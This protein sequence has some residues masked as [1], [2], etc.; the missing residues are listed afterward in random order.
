M[1]ANQA[2]F[3]KLRQG[4]TNLFSEEDKKELPPTECIGD[5]LHFSSSTYL[6]ITV[7]EESKEQLI[8][9][10]KHSNFEVRNHRFELQYEL[11][12][13]LGE[14]AHAVVKLCWPRGA[15]SDDLFAVKITRSGDQEIMENMR[16]TFLNSISLNHPYVV[17][18]YKLYIDQNEETAY[19]LMDYCPFPS[20]EKILKEKTIL[21][22]PQA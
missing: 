11:G 8:K 17:K 15:N 19:L 4:L 16:V 7:T 2:N 14:G 21:S 12:R 22:E 3:N 9:S 10:I 6:G 5:S 13:S 1:K 18:H 20:L